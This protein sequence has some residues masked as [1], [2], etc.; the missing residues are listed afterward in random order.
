MSQD[1]ALELKQ[2]QFNAAMERYEKIGIYKAIYKMVSVV[3]V[4][5]QFYLLYLVLP[6]SIGLPLQLAGFYHGI[7]GC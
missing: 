6:V 5:L 4:S 3:N 2:K 7:S 1:Q